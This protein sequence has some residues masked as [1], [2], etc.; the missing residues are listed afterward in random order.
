MKKDWFNGKIQSA[1]ID[2]IKSTLIIVPSVCFI[3][4]TAVLLALIFGHNVS[5]S[6][7]ICM[8]VLSA[9]F[10]L[11][12]VLYPL[13]SIKVIR[14]YP[15]HKHVAHA[16]IKKY[17]FTD[18]S[19]E[20]LKS[21][22]SINVNPNQV[23]ENILRY[24]FSK[25]TQEYLRKHQ[26]E[27]NVL[28][29]STLALEFWKGKKVGIFEQLRDISA[30]EYERKLLDIAL[31]DIRKFNDIDERTISF[32]LKNDPRGNDKPN[33]PF[34]EKIDLP[35]LFKVGDVVIFEDD[36][37]NYYLVGKEPVITRDGDINDYSYLC[38]LINAPIDN[39][40]KLFKAHS[41]LNVCSVNKV[42]FSK[43]PKNIKENISYTLELVNKELWM[44]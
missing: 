29:W 8:S 41:H 2:W 24:I 21:I 22:I 5:T 38:Y 23:Y 6:T 33:L 25:E 4:G 14:S 11:F 10:Y 27:L 3:I 15:K 32:Y 42:P 7:N 28:Q 1:Y 34:N 31:K 30:T 12:A 19:S 20:F 44:K 9:L 40:D 39:A 35:I 36:E 43:I 16:L 18:Y 17:A 13:V 26:D 37:I